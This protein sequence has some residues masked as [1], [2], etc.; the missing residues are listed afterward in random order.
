[1]TRLVQQYLERAKE[2]EERASSLTDNIQK[3][4]WREIA[5]AY[6]TLAQARL[7]DHTTSEQPSEASPTGHQK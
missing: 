7:T 4:R 1:M 2:A 6:R 5:T 3:K